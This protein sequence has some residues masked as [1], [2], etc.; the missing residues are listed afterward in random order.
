MWLQFTIYSNYHITSW[1]SVISN[2]LVL[3]N[4]II[5]FC[6]LEIPIC[7]LMTLTLSAQINTKYLCFAALVLWTDCNK[8]ASQFNVSY[9]NCLSCKQLQNSIIWRPLVAMIKKSM[10]AIQ[11]S[12]FF[13]F[14]LV[15]KSNVCQSPLSLANGLVW[16]RWGAVGRNHISCCGRGANR[17]YSL[18]LIRWVSQ[19]FSWTTGVRLSIFTS[20]C[21]CWYK[22][23]S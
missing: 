2:P 1:S 9:Y 22:S 7:T 6:L 13:S 17:S 5:I 11:E 10:T 16:S 23:Q 4:F 18:V 20:L 19:S 15:A 3:F 12:F 14:F 8:L 21:T